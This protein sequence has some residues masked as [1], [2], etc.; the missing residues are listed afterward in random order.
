MSHS[1]NSHDSTSAL[2]ALATIFQDGT[3]PHQDQQTEAW[4]NMFPEIVGRSPTMLRLL[5]SVA[6]IARSDSAVL[7]HGESGTG[8]ELIARAIHRL[9]HR[10]SKP[11]LALN[12]SA[13]PENLLES[14]LFGHERGAF[15]GAD[16][17]HHGYFERANQG[18]LFLDEIGDMAPSLQA[19]LLRVLQEKKFT[20]VGGKDLIDADVRILTATHVNLDHAIAQGVFRRDLFYRINVLPVFLPALH[21]R[22]EDIPLLI[23]HFLEIANRMHSAQSP[24]Y[25]DVD[26][27]EV[28]KDYRWPGNIRQLQN[29]VERLVVLKGGGRID[30]SYV[31]REIIEETNQRKTQTVTMGMAEHLG[32]PISTF[33][34]ATL[35]PR[36]GVSPVT[37]VPSNFGVLPAQGIDLDHFIE[38]LENALITQAL[39]RTDNNR[40]Q[41][42]KLL[43]MNR[44]TLVERI[45]KRKLTKLNPPSE[46]L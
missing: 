37:S 39:E 34:T 33:Q 29:V 19:K 42:A 20:P 45:K 2:A 17:R 14:Q 18:T 1:D 25:F 21:E 7:I 40:N 38:S 26:I 15:T 31:P 41:A 36:P 35:S 30:L 4:M 3:H 32:R 12:C 43:G 23:D 46:E 8:K 24:C 28:L 5:E 22:K 11:F 6:K 44:T 27:L 10:A 9:S 13:I 16:K